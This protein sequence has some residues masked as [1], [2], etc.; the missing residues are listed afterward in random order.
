MVVYLLVSN[1]EAVE[2]FKKGECK[3]SDKEMVIR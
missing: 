3:S 2:R 1:V